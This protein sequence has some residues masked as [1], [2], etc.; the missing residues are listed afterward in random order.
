MALGGSLHQAVHELPGF[1]THHEKDED[2]LHVQYGPS[3]EVR[4][5]PEGLLASLTGR[6]S[7]VVNSV[8]HQGVDRLAD[9]LVVEAIAPDGLI[10]AF[11]VQDAPGFTLAV[12]W[13]PEWN[14]AQSRL[15]TAIFQAF[16]EACRRYR[17]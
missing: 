13:H 4:F 1:G 10:E 6:G 15:S 16:G 8:H 17:Q 2:P 9:G 11:T 3:H 7:A 12:Q 14:A 5:T